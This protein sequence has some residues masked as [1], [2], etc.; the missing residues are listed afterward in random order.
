MELLATLILDEELLD[1]TLPPVPAWSQQPACLQVKDSPRDPGPAFCV[2]KSSTKFLSRAALNSKLAAK[3]LSCT[4]LGLHFVLSTVGE[5]VFIMPIIHE[6]QQQ[7]D[8]HNH[9]GSMIFFSKKASSACRMW[10]PGLYAPVWEAVSSSLHSSLFE[11]Y[12]SSH[13]TVRIKVW[14]RDFWVEFIWIC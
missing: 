11:V 4:H 12:L 13:V 7:R 6:N 10:M 14:I 1:R 2:T 9:D 5:T 3:S 8:L